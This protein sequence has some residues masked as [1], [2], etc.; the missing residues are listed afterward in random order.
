MK[1]LYLCLQLRIVFIITVI[2]IGPRA[3][4]P[5]EFSSHGHD[6]DDDMGI[7]ENVRLR[8]LSHQYKVQY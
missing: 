6:D 5:V 7:V 1:L 8:W 2:R 4:F 3:E